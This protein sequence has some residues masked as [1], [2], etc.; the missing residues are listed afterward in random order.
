GLFV[1]RRLFR[2]ELGI[3]IE[4]FVRPCRRLDVLAINAGGGG[5]V[6]AARLALGLVRG[7]GDIDRDRDLDFRMQRYRHL[8][9]ADRLDRLLQVHLAAADREAGAGDQL[10]NV[11]GRHRTVEL[12]GLARRADDDEF[13]TVEI[14]AD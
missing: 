8:R 12:A 14:L 11:P 1:L 4:E 13:L 3:G 5:Q 10:G 2:L 7:P 9:D 6:F